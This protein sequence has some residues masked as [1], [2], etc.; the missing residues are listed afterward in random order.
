MG[1]LSKTLIPG[2]LA[3]VTPVSPNINRLYDLHEYDPDKL[4]TGEI[5]PNQI[6]PVIYPTYEKN[7]KGIVVIDKNKQTVSNQRTII[8]LTATKPSSKKF[9]EVVDTEIQEFTQTLNSESAFLSNQVAALDSSIQRSRSENLT[10]QKKITDLN[11]EIDSLR[12]QL[13]LAVDP[14]KDNN[15][16]DT[17]VA[18]SALFS[19]RNSQNKL[20]SR[21]RTARAVLQGDGDL[22][23]YSGT[24]DYDGLPIGSERVVWSRGFDGKKDGPGVYMILDITVG[25]NGKL[26]T[27][28]ADND[29]YQERFSTPVQTLSSKARVQLTDAGILNLFDGANIIWS[30]YGS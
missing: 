22:V 5:D 16:S 29:T 18:G 13:E 30:S 12:N 10:L 8:N 14:A 25:E 2:Q 17:L 20:L 24:Y 1:T 27:V 7:Y 15:V 23:I 9:N 11:S 6:D 3:E 21:N 19:D 26:A 4:I 28:R